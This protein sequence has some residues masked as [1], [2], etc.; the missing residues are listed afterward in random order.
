MIGKLRSN[1][2]KYESQELELC[3]GMERAE[4]LEKKLGQ[5]GWYR[6]YRWDAA[7]MVRCMAVDD[8]SS[9]GGFVIEN[10]YATKAES[11]LVAAVKAFCLMQ[12]ARRLRFLESQEKIRQESAGD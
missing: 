11:E 2:E 4:D 10:D 12:R 6:V 3:E 1:F 9:G 5:A 8:L 7:G